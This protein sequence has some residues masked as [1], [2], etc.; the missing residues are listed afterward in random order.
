MEK[1]AL[2]PETQNKCHVIKK[3]DVY[4]KASD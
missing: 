3:K 4:A 1:E 2:S